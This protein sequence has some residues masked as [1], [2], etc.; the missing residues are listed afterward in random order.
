M[1]LDTFNTAIDNEACTVV[2][3]G[4][5]VTEGWNAQMEGFNIYCEY[6]MRTLESK[7]PDV[8]FTFYNFGLASRKIENYIDTEFKGEATEPANK[9]DGYYRPQETYAW[10]E[11]STINQTWIGKVDAKTPDLVIMEFGINDT[12]HPEDF[13]TDYASALTTMQAWTK[14]PSILLM[15][16]ILPT[17]DSDPYIDKNG[18]IKAYNR[19]VRTLA[20][21]KNCGLLDV[22][23]EW[24]ILRDGR[25]PLN[26]M[27]EQISLDNLTLVS[28]AAATSRTYNSLVK[29]SG[30]SI[31]GVTNTSSDYEYVSAKLIA[32]YDPDGSA[33]I[34]S[35]GVR[36]LK[37]DAW[38]EGVSVQITDTKAK[39]WENGTLKVNNTQSEITQGQDNAIEIVIG[40]YDVTVTINTNEVA[41]Y[42][43]DTKLDYGRIAVGVKN[44]T[45]SDAYLVGGRYETIHTPE[46]T[47]NELLGNNTG[48]DWTN[49]DYSEGGNSLNH[50]SRTGLRRAFYPVITNFLKII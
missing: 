28:G 31:Y 33:A 38:S 30:T 8:T 17:M 15:T 40:K 44:G 46:F 26:Y 20:G 2:F 49:G 35:L 6:F 32:D 16:S 21:E 4:T 18:L 13:K 5:S 11:A 34:A 39:I 50:P 43:S 9:N 14:S 47:N 36:Y 7:Y 37:T 24:Q 42:T 25:D 3:V 23:R 45:L 29:T 41:T 19:E 27:E 22:G 48:T 10:Q 12:Q 1:N